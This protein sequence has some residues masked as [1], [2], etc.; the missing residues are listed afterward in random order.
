MKQKIYV[1]A[2]DSSHV[3]ALK[4]QG[5]WIDL[6]SGEDVDLE[7]PYVDGDGKVVYDFKIFSL[8]VGMI[9]P[10]G[11]EAHVL[12]RSSFFKKKGCILAN[13]EGMI[14]QTYS[15]EDDIWRFQALAFRRTH[16][17][18][19]DVIAQFKIVPSQK[20]T[21]WQKLKWLFSNG[22]EIVPVN[23]LNDVNRGGIGSTGGM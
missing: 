16:I 4:P 19:T 10:P 9:L 14:D 22:V 18:S 5:D 3:P 23:K 20:A 21:P 6:L 13:S 8:G 11:M 7:A 15:G 1:K 12:P 17:K 2:V